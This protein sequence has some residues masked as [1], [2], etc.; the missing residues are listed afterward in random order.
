M[1]VK[2]WNKTKK[3][4]ELI[5]NIDSV[6]CNSFRDTIDLIRGGK[7]TSYDDKVYDLISVNEV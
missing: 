6:Y 7:K 1:Q 3:E 4:Y 5:E 2:L